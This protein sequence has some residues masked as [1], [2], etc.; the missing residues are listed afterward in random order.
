MST[1]SKRSAYTLVETLVVI[2]II[3]VLIGLLL[4][5]VQAVRGRAARL[6]CADNLKQ[7]GL[8]LHQYHNVHKSFPPGLSNGDGTD[9]YQ[10]GRA[11]V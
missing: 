8:A 5:A 4:P 9:P 3:A 1:S 11:H 6:Q 10:I 7:I 2:A